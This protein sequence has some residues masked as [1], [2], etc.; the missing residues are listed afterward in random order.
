MNPLGIEVGL[1]TQL[2]SV[3]Q[4]SYVM[5]YSSIIYSIYDSVKVLP[6][7]DHRVW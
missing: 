4:Q 3:I 2:W 5:T 1:R 6:I 7:I